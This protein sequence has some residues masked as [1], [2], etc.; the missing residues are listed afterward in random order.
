MRPVQRR[1]RDVQ[2][3]TVDEPRVVAEEEG[4]EERTDVRAIHVGVGHDDDLVVPQ[5]VVIGVLL[6]DARAHRGDERLDF[7]VGEHLVEAGAFRVQDLASQ[8]QN[9]LRVRVA[10]LLGRTACGVTFH[11]EQFGI[12]RVL[13][14]AVGQLAGQRVVRKGALAADKLLGTA[15][16]IAGA[17]GVH[18]LVD[19]Q[20]GVFGV[21]LK[22]GVELAVH[23]AAHDARDLAV[24]E[25]GLGLAFELRLGELH[26][27]HGGQPFADVVAGKGLPLHLLGQ[28]GLALDVVVDGA[29]QRGLEPGKVRTAFLRANVVREGI[30]VFLVARVV[31]DGELHGNAVGH[32][33]PVDDGVDAHF[34]GVQI[35]H[36]LVDTALGMEQMDFAG[37]LVAALDLEALV[38]I[39]QLLK[40]LLEGVV[41][42]FRGLENGFVGLEADGRAVA[43]GLTNVLELLLRHAPAVHLL[44]AFPVPA[45]GHLKALGKRVDA[46]DAHAVQAARHLVGGVVELAARVELGHDHLNG[47]DLLLGVDV[48]GDAAPVVADRDAVVHV[49]HDFDAR[50]VARHRFVDGVVHHFVHEVMQTTV[51][52]AADVHGRAFPHGLETFKNSD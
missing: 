24:A 41:G 34:A 31:L 17:G 12:R 25:L 37:A 26:A 18:G 30:H 49:E 35:L 19:D 50:A 6:A 23:H 15:G 9:G 33:F 29:G 32:A 2:V 1:L 10:P 48:H 16:R 36:E 47:G 45:D 28:I 20:A 22:I 27:E 42:E 7:L 21:L 39:R 38:Q 4:Q 11:D 46:G 14:L 44:P 43:V 51:I 3:A 8:G 5:L 40:T 13:A 52:R